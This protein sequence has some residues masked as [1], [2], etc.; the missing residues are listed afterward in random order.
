MN[1]R[2][3]D[4]FSFQEIQKDAEGCNKILKGLRMSGLEGAAGPSVIKD[5]KL[6]SGVMTLARKGRDHLL[7]AK[8]RDG[9]PK[10]HGLYGHT[11]K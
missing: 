4:V 8:T 3:G 5:K 2:R 9:L 6:C 1:N 7:P 10:A 11:A